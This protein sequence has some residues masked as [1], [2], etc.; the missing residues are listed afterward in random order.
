M[1]DRARVHPLDRG[2]EWFVDKSCI[3]CDVARMVAPGLIAEAPDGRSFFTRAP[4]SVAE[5]TMAWRALLACPS[6]SIGAPRGVK[7]AADAFPFEV[8]PG[9]HLCGFN[10]ADSFGAN[11][12]FVP[13]A[14]G[15]LLI[16][17]PR[18]VT[19]L[20]DAFD[21]QGGVTD[22]LLTHRDD[23]A[24]YARYA[25]RF[26]ARVW[27]HELEKSA[28]P[29]ATDIITEDREVA[30]GVRALVLPGHTRGSVAFLVDDRFLFT[31]DSLYW[32]RELDD[33]NAFANAT[34]YSWPEL[35]ASLARLADAA[36]FE[37]VLPG[38]GMWGRAD[39]DDMRARLVA[40][41]ARMR[42][43]ETANAW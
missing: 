33:L 22:I 18:Y 36:R 25:K 17:A 11:A 21:A 14:S 30:P 13:R 37:W 1:A 8:A 7:P 34:W 35:T 15:N 43:G 16:D 5:E 3:D 4:A 19:H 32:S 40:L 39:P 10:S 31:G 23:V 2:G 29:T 42:A 27:I 28:A 9:V 20:V 41:V 6:G 24:D 26:G 38:H 12:W